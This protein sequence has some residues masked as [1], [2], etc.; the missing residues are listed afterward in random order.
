MLVYTYDY[1]STYDPA[2]PIIEI[3]IGAVGASPML[4][5]NALIDS[6]ADGTIIPLH[7]LKQIGARKYQKKWLRTITGQRV[8]IDLY[9]IVVQLG[10]MQPVR[11]A[12]AGD[13]QLNEAVVGRDLLNQLVVK[14]DGPAMAVEVFVS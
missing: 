14:L 2:M 3:N 8:Q 4:M 5:I 9:L 12:V 13:P 7:V 11:L 6:G 1:E 10:G